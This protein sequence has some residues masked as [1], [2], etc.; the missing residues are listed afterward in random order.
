MDQTNRNFGGMNLTSGD[1][2]LN[3][4]KMSNTLTIYARRKSKP[5]MYSLFGK[6]HNE[7]P[8]FIERTKQKK[9]ITITIKACFFDCFEH[10]LVFVVIF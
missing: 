1:W 2:H 9:K 6:K 7:Q 10:F 4:I 8:H 3:I 5:W